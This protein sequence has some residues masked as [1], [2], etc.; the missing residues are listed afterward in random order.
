MMI[1]AYGSLEFIS[2]EYG[3]PVLRDDLIESLL[4]GLYLFLDRL[5]SNVVTLFPDEI[6]LVS[7]GDSDQCPPGDQLHR[8]CPLPQTRCHIGSDLGREVLLDQVLVLL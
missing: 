2:G 5:V 7:I 4:Q 6:F 3:H 1:P 8:L